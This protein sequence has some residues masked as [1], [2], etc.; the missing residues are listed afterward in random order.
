MIYFFT[1]N[2]H[3]GL[4]QKK[5]DLIKMLQEKQPGASVVQVDPDQIT[6]SFVEGLFETQGLFLD[7]QIVSFGQVCEDKDRWV[8]LKKPLK[9]FS[10]RDDVIIWSEIHTKPLAPLKKKIEEIK[11]LAQ[12]TVELN[13]EEKSLDEKSPD[14]FIFAGQ[15]FGLPKKDL[16]VAF[17]KI[18]DEVADGDIPL[19]M[20]LWQTRAILQSKASNVED[21][22][23]KPF[24]YKKSRAILDRRGEKDIKNTLVELTKIGQ[25]MRMDKIKGYT[26]LEK[27]ILNRS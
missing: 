26:L 23:L 17:Q 20:L 22:G 10:E 24:V 7:K 25:E 11:K 15:F 13:K 8:V 21:S 18:R 9:D 16:W 6:A 1:G 2:D 14:L 19:N 4:I 27:Y 12:K 5:Q 3:R